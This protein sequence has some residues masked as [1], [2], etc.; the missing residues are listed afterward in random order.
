V[1]QIVDMFRKEA[2][3]KES[4]LKSVNTEEKHESI[5]AKFGLP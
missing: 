4:Q 3:P 2:A 1:A 5:K